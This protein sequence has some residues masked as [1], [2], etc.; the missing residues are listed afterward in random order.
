MLTRV[1]VCGAYAHVGCQRSR[2]LEAC[3]VSKFGN[4]HSRGDVADAANGSQE[5]SDLMLLEGACDFP[6]QPLKPFAQGLEILAGIAHAE[7]MAGAML[8]ADRDRRRIDQLLRQLRTYLVA[9]V[10][11]EFR[12]PLARDSA[13]SLCGRILMQDRAG[14]FGVEVFEIAR[15]LGKTQIHQSMQLIESR[16]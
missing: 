1:F 11:A 15:E 16:D 6:I 7:L 4:D 8:T 3:G 9:T 10:I 5:L 12:Q 14:E 13:Q 2:A